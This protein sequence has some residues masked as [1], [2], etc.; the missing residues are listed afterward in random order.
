MGVTIHAGLG[1][2]NIGVG[3]FFHSGVAVA[4]VH[5]KLIHVKRVVEG[6]RLSGLVAY[7]CVFWG[8]IISH[9]GN[10]AGANHC[11]THQNF[12]RQPVGVAGENIGQGFLG[13]K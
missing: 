3:G 10:H 8:K 13:K 6:D 12:D 4:T 11:Q 5:S 1:A 9:P 2:R 7:A